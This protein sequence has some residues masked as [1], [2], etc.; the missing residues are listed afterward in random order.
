MFAE[1]AEQAYL[2]GML[3][4]S[5]TRKELETAAHESCLWF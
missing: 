5:N 3:A 1:D 4:I 2:L